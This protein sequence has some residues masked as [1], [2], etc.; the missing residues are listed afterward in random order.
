[1]ALVLHSN[2]DDPGDCKATH[3]HLQIGQIYKRTVALRAETQWIWALNGV[4]EGPPGQPI[5]GSAATRDEALTALTERWA[6]W[7]EW[8]NLS[9]GD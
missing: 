9:E 8:A 1:M 4:S 5:T 6:K 3:G 7:L 2:P